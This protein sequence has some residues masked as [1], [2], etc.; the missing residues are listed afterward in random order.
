MRNA[1]V[2]LNCE[3]CEMRDVSYFGFPRNPIQTKVWIERL[4]PRLPAN[5]TE[6][7][8]VSKH[9]CSLHFPPETH[10]HHGMGRRLFPNALPF[11]IDEHSTTNVSTQCHIVRDQSREL[12]ELKKQH[13]ILKREY[14]KL[15]NNPPTA[16]IIRNLYKLK[17]RV[18]QE[19]FICFENAIHN[20]DK[21][22][23]NR[24]HTLAA[25][26]LTNHI[27]VQSNEAFKLFRSYFALPSNRTLGRHYNQKDQISNDNGNG[28]VTEE[29]QLISD[30]L[31][32]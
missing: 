15:K 17:P 5:F 30:N 26:Q 6:A 21:H 13:A 3:S 16:F 22:P 25:K 28:N 20:Y 24:R 31:I 12:T 1:C 32:N 29:T 23:Q 8:S 7:D 11:I 9:I 18:S 27:Q 2:I 4:R 19:A 14:T 10:Y